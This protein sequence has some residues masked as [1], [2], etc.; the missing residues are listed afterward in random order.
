MLLAPLVSYDPLS[1][2]FKKTEVAHRNAEAIFNNFPGLLGFAGRGDQRR[3]RSFIIV[4]PIVIV[5]L[6][7][8]RVVEWE[9]DRD[10]CVIVCTTII[11]ILFS[12]FTNLF[13]SY[14]VVFRSSDQYLCQDTT[15]SWVFQG[16]NDVPLTIQITNSFSA[17]ADI[18]PGYSRLM[19]SFRTLTTDVPST[20]AQLD[21]SPVD[22]DEGFYTA[23]AFDTSR[24]AGLYAQSQPFFVAS[25]QN[26]TS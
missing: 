12:A 7:V 18:K 6:F 19:I 2:I 15:F 5:H 11:S 26:R 4:F 17:Q 3:T 10:T 13:I 8:L 20:A 14:I 16:A 25:G 9:L 1:F 24:A 22:V 21:W 23:I